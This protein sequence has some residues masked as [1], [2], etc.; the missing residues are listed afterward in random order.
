[1][2]FHNTCFYKADL[3]DVVLHRIWLDNTDLREAN[4]QGTNFGEFP[5]LKCGSDVFSVAYSKG[6][7]QMAIELYNG[8]IALYKK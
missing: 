1:L 5:S 7:M 3:E 8:N 4:L 2:V 6:E